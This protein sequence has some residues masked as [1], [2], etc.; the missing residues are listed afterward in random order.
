M[1]ASYF[2]KNPDVPEY[3]RQI[4]VDVKSYMAMV[5]FE[6]GYVAGDR[7]VWGTHFNLIVHR[8][9]DLRC[10]GA[11]LSGLSS[12]E[13]LR[14]VEDLTFAASGERELKLCAPVLESLEAQVSSAPS[15]TSE[16]IDIAGHSSSSTLANHPPITAQAKIAKSLRS[17]RAV[18]RSTMGLGPP[19]RGLGPPR[20]R[21]TTTELLP[22]RKLRCFAAFQLFTQSYSKLRRNHSRQ[23]AKAKYS[24]WPSARAIRFCGGR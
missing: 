2:L 7:R 12:V 16:T 22:I 18:G 11:L 6:R 17:W 4:P 10:L 9:S 14:A 8:N 5:E 1:A 19:L 15:F 20:L 24:H 3:L 21:Q 23:R 13:A